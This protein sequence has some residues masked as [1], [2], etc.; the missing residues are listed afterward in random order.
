MNVS[1]REFLILVENVWSVHDH[2]HQADAM[3]DA[4]TRTLRRS[5][6]QRAGDPSG[7]R[8]EA[9]RHCAV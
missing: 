5:E 1:M 3:D 8:E 7:R 9:G 2:A 6:N 4:T